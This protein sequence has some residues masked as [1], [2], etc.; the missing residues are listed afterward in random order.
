MKYRQLVFLF[1]LL[2]ACNSV[3]VVPIDDEDAGD[4]G[5][6][7]SSPVGDAAVDTGADGG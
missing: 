7:A 6:E 4:A 2:A 3:T 5:P 1:A